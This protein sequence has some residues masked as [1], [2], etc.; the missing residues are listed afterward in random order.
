MAG[1]Y[2][3]RGLAQSTR[4]SYE[5]PRRSFI[6]FCTLSGR[7]HSSGSCLPATGCWLIEWITS[8]AGRV[9]VKTMKQ[10]L[11]GLRSYHVDLGLP[12][13]A[14]QDERLERVI[15]GIKREHAEPDRRQRSPL[16]RDCLLRI[17]RELRLPSYTNKTLRAA[18]TLAF[19]GFL[20]VGEFTYQAVDLELGPNFRNWFLT[21]SSIKISHDRSHMSVYLPASKTD[22]F[23]H[24]VEIFIAAT[25]DEACPVRAMDEFLRADTHRPLLAPL[26]VADLARQAP[27]TREHVVNRLRMLAIAAGLGAGAWNGHSFRRGAATWAAEVGISEQQIQELG[28]WTSSAYRSYIETSREDRIALSQRFQRA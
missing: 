6:R 27:F 5:T 8:L 16:T 21:K 2:L 22:P 23:R 28:R 1:F 20:R 12:V 15:R 3:W 13:T 11:S 9:K 4:R 25:G 24:G 7:R 10:Y 14:F 18:F 17:L 19:A 26:F